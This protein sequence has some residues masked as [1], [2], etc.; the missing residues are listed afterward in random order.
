[1]PLTNDIINHT[2]ATPHG[3]AAYKVVE[4]LTDSGFDTWWV[5]GCVREMLQG[6]I[7]DDIDIATEAKPK[8][9]QNVFKRTR[10]EGE[11]F[12]SMRITIGS[13]TF[14]VTTFREDDEASDGRHPESV[15]FGTRE[16]DAARRDIT[17]NAIY[18]NPISRALYDPFGG[19]AD[20][21]EKLIRIIGEPGIRL[22]H[23]ALRLL[24]VVRFR[25]KIAG[26][27]HPETYEALREQAHL[28]EVLSGTRVREE[29]EKML[30][31]PHVDRAFEDL[32]EL[33]I[34]QYILPELY[35]CK[36]IPQPGEYHQEGDVWDHLMECTRHYREEDDV[37]TRLAALF[38]D[39][40]KATTFSLEKRIMFAEHASVSGDLAKAA[41]DRLQCLADRRDKIVWS[42]KHHMMMG[43]FFQ[44][45]EVRKAHWYYHPW[46]ATLLRVFYLDCAGTK[47]SDFE[48]YEKIRSDYHHFLDTHPRP[49]KPL[50][51]GHEVMQM[52]GISAGEKVGEVL[53]T[54][55]EAQLRHEITSKEEAREFLKK[56]SMGGVG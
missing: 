13:A 22:K 26:Q 1:M 50:L 47:P 34:L 44:M 3:E 56:W 4:Q 23:D 18:W 51:S 45:P 53:K 55:H 46:F 48:L 5:G 41:L 38:H 7:P 9:I 24:R 21:H 36:G 14:E 17:I 11:I 19:E 52:L 33:G 6:S 54:L 20:L 2:L 12:G 16:N 40:G 28:I 43:S 15:V 42:V 25:A 37:D 35:A 39:V 8:D 27:Y 29:L 30:M 31:G 49:P 10:P 32:W